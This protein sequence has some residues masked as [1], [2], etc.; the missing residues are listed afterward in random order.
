ML[1]VHEGIHFN[2]GRWQ[3]D[4]VEGDAPDDTNAIQGLGGAELLAFQGFENKCVDGRSHP[5]AGPHLPRK[6]SK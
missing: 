3:A 5:G 4:Q 2:R 1:K 6:N